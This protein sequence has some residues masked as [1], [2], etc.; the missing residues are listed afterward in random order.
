MRMI[1]VFV[2]ES[3]GE[4]I[5]KTLRWKECMEAKGLKV[6]TSN[7]TVTVSGKNC[8]DIEKTGK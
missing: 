6:N 2:A 1:L 3:I 4:L 5:K 7:T 8:G